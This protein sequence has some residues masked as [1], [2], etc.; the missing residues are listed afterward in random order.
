MPPRISISSLTSSS[1]SAL[2]ATM[3]GIPPEAATFRA[4]ERPIPLEAPVITTV[5]PLIAASRER[6]LKRSG[7]ILRSQ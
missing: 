7:S 1:F 2:R 6:L 4:V 5:R 3:I